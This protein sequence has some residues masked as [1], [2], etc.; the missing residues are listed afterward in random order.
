MKNNCFV[1]FLGMLL[2]CGLLCCAAGAGE[3]VA[4]AAAQTI[5]TEEVKDAAA[6]AGQQKVSLAQVEKSRAVTADRLYGLA[7]FWLLIALAV[8]LIRLQTRDDER[9]YDEGYYHKDP[10]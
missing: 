2:L 5:Q 7:G 8:Y 10:E 6:E 3:P 1:A 9:L 4:P